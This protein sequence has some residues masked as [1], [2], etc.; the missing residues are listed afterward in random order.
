MGGQLL[1]THAEHLV[2]LRSCGSAPTNRRRTVQRRNRRHLHPYGTIEI[3]QRLALS[4]S[5]QAR[6]AAALQ[7]PVSTPDLLIALCAD[8]TPSSSDA[9]A[10]DP[11]HCE[12]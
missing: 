2:R 8:G 11:A 4:P 9:D 7:T 10:F 3:R 1:H 5:R 6:Y 12:S